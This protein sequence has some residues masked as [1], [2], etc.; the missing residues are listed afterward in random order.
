MLRRRMGDARFFE[1]LAELR[2]RYEWKAVSTEQ[3]RALAARYLPPK[4]PD[5]DLAAFFDQWV[6]GTGIPSLKL[7]YSVKGS[8]RT[9]RLQ[10]TMK[11]GDAGSRFLG[12]GTGRNS[13]RQGQ[14]DHSRGVQR[15]GA[16]R[17]LG[18]AEAGARQ[19]GAGPAVERAAAVDRHTV[20]PLSSATLK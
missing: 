4:S 18:T 8:G 3:F 6:Y 7:S 5:A 1:M 20:A 12:P 14:I 17:V 2:R 9:L 13:V 15:G 19:G 10:G 16:C 11:Q